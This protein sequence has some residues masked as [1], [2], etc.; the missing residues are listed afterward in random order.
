MLQLMGKRGSRYRWLAPMT[1]AAGL[2]T[3]PACSGDEQQQAQDYVCAQLENLSVEQ[4]DTIFDRAAGELDAVGIQIDRTMWSDPERF[5]QLLDAVARASG[6]SELSAQSV[7]EDGQLAQA[8]GADSNYCGPGHDR[9]LTPTVAPCLNQVCRAHDACYAQCSVPIEA[10]CTWS[11]VTKPCDD[12]FFTSASS[13]SLRPHWFKSHFVLFVARRMASSSLLDSC[14]P[15]ASCPVPPQR[16]AGV[17]GMQADFAR[18]N[19][20]LDRLDPER[21]C[22]NAACNG[23]ADDY[24]CYSATCAVGG[25]YGGWDSGSGGT[26][27]SGGAGGSGA[28]GSG[29]TGGSGGC[30]PESQCGSDCCTLNEVCSR[31]GLGTE[32]C[33]PSCTTNTDCAGASDCCVVL[34]GGGGVCKPPIS[35]LDSCKCFTAADCT[36]SLSGGSA[37]VP[38]VLSGAVVSAARVCRPDDGRV[39]NGCN[40]FGVV[41]SDDCMTDALGNSF[42]TPGCEASSTC[43]A[44]GVACCLPAA[45]NNAFFSCAHAS[46]CQPC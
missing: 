8:L 46:A 10:L 3:S 20:C 21:A 18:C 35:G 36:G 43:G 6:C 30:S 34:Q 16:G 2:F 44:P 19:E 24:V 28:A 41:C 38:F 4:M 5:G 45:C 17:C 11:P 7:A 15:G 14:P 12:T 29:G 42:C 32:R 23:N 25:C 33:M 1:L 22:L 37:C 9:A 31:D 26:S 27:G 39:G 13:C 40:G